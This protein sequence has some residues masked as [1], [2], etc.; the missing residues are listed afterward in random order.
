MGFLEYGYVNQNQNWNGTAPSTGHNNSQEIQTYFLTAGVQYMWNR[1]W[2]ISA[3]IPYWTRHFLGKDHTHN[4][5]NANYG[6]LGDI[7]IKAIYTGLSETMSSGILFGL[8]LPTGSFTEPTISRDTQIG[9]G[10]TDLVV[11]AYHMGHLTAD[12][13]WGW[14]ANIQWAQPV[15]IQADYRPGA[16]INGV[17]GIYYE[18]W[19]IG[20]MAIS[21]VLQLIGTQRW[22]DSGAQAEPDHSGYQRLLLSPGVEVNMGRWH[23]YAN[24]GLP[25]Y[26][27]TI[28]NQ[29]VAPQFFK[30]NAGYRF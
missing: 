11:G 27:N 2:G 12:Q 16:E 25:I 21:P 13:N 8:K 14:V 19:S 29:L 22:T 18:G 4:T 1:Q 7:R 28:G 20:N 23:V 24:I 10:S 5:I 26:Q 9:T 15:L 6:S 17:L 30:L 3:E